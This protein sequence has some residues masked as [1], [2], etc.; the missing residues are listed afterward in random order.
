MASLEYGLVP[1]VLVFVGFVLI[2]GPASLITTRLLR[3][4]RRLVATIATARPGESVEI[5]DDLRKRRDEVGLLSEALVGMCDRVDGFVERERRF[6]R[7]ASHELRTPVTVASGALDLLRRN[8][9]LDPAARRAVD[10]IERANRDMADLIEA[11][12]LLA[13][14]RGLDDLNEDLAID[15]L[16]D[17]AIANHAQQIERR[18]LQFERVGPGSLSAAAPAT[19]ARIVFRNLI[20]N[21]ITHAKGTV[22]TIT[23]EHSPVRVTIANEADAPSEGQSARRGFGLTIAADCCRRLGWQLDLNRSVDRF[24]VTITFL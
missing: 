11:F 19:I 4:L 1:V 8:Q 15:A 24:V 20:R 9:S 22:V 16:L 10:R 13:R 23:T 18:G 17:D 2:L 5:A 14:E 7:D 6:S 21:A 3:P 12:L